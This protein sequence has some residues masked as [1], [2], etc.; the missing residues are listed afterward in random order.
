[1]IELTQA[2]SRACWCSRTCWV[3]GRSASRAGGRLPNTRKEGVVAGETAH[4]V[5]RRGSPVGGVLGPGAA[6]A[7][8]PGLVELRD[9]AVAGEVERRRA[10]ALIG[11]ERQLWPE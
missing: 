9:W 11:L 4:G 2:A 5:A 6:A 8:A 1:M 7:P 10:A 3:V